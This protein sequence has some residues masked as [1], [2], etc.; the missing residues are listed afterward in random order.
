MP[1]TFTY[2]ADRD[3]LL[4]VGTGR[5]TGDDFGPGNLPDYPVGTPE[6]LDV[7]AVTDADVTGADIRR[8]AELERLGPNRISR[9]AIV[10]GSAV[11][12]GLSRMFQMLADEADYQIEVFRELGDALKWIDREIPSR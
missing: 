11:T 3:L 1:L 7:R 10:T 5:L 6:L 12:Y 8:I 4:G 9:M 2:D